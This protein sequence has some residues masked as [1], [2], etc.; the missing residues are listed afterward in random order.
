MSPSK[1]RK[2]NA[3]RDGVC[4]ADGGEDLR[5]RHTGEYREAYDA[6]YRE[7]S[8]Y[9]A[10]QAATSD[11][12]YTIIRNLLAHAVYDRERSDECIEAVAAA[13]QYLGETVEAV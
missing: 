11:D 5:A 9:L 2:T 7:H 13:E 6:G 4:H 1:M 3:F 8:D 10:R 12:P